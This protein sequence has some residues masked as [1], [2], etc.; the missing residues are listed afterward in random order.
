MPQTVR[1]VKGFQRFIKGQL[2]TVGGGVADLWI[3]QGRAAPVQQSPAPAVIETAAVDAVVETADRT[4]R[5]RR[6]S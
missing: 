3:K 5:R 2:V 4:P 6:R 1:I